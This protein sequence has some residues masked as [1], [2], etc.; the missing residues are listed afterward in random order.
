MAPKAIGKISTLCGLVCRKLT[1]TLSDFLVV[2]AVLFI[3]D[4]FWRV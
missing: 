4:S 2:A 3:H 1:A